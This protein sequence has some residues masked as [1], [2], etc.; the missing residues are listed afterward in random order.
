MAGKDYVLTI[1]AINAKHKM[2]LVS[3]P[4]IFH[5]PEVEPVKNTEK[6]SVK[7]PLAAPITHLEATNVTSEQI[8]I[9][10]D[11]IDDAKVY[12]LK[13]DKGEGKESSL[14]YDLVKNSKENTF[15]L[16]KANSEG[17]LGTQ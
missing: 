5:V 2:S 1:Q 12:H 15:V 8:S 13:W 4:A 10:W 3:D 17:V 14:F 9:K 6:H 7:S 16:T 11:K